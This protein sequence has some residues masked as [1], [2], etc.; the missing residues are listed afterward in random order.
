MHETFGEI[1]V[2]IFTFENFLFTI[3]CRFSCVFQ[4]NWLSFVHIAE[5]CFTADFSQ[6]L[7]L[8]R[9]TACTRVNLE[10]KEFFSLGVSKI[11][12]KKT[13]TFCGLIGV[14]DCA[15]VPRLVGSVNS[16]SSSGPPSTSFCLSIDLS[17][18]SILIRVFVDYD[19][20]L[21]FFKLH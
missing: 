19:S 8:L 4:L 1:E 16:S 17:S 18:H 2:G 5:L 7:R 20:N 21:N 9:I 11:S 6:R 14:F 12:D 10:Q 13:L 3:W 15:V